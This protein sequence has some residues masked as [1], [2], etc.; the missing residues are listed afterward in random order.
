MSFLTRTTIVRSVRFAQVQ[1]PR[2]FSTSFVARK[3]ATEAVKDTVKDTVKIVD[4]KVSN[5][6]V[7]GIEVGRMSLQVVFLR[8][9][10]DL[11]PLLGHGMTVFNLLD[12]LA[13]SFISS[14]S[15]NCF[16]HTLIHIPKQKPQRKKPGKSLACQQ[17]RPRA[18][19]RS[20]RAK[21]RGSQRSSKVRPRERRR[22]SRESYE[23]FQ[24]Q[25]SEWNV[26]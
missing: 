11:F 22:S 14:R 17:A 19:Q 3:S 24:R 1:A 16:E 15:F 4:R 25:Q 20:S 8:L 6:L 21:Q 26:S 23:F 18:R 5:T 10:Y 2:A 9:L 7:G 12:S 13:I